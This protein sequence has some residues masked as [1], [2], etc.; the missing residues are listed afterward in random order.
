MASHSSNREKE[1]IKTV[2]LNARVER[3]DKWRS[4]WNARKEREKDLDEKGKQLAQRKKEL[5]DME[6]EGRMKHQDNSEVR[7]TASTF[8]IRNSSGSSGLS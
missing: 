1:N 2:D 4:D 5:G 7:A 8:S 3:L 6:M